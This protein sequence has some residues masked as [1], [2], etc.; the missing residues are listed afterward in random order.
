MKLVISCEHGGNEIPKQYENIFKNNQAV[1]DTHKGFDLGALDLFRYLKPLSE[2]S[3]SSK[4]SRLLIELNRSLH[5]K[6]LFSK[7]T[8]PLS[9]SEKKVIIENQYF[10]YRNEIES[11]ISKLIFNG[12][13]VLHISIHSFTPILNGIERDC[14][15]GILYDSKKQ[16]EKN[17]A[18]QLKSKINS[19][20]PVYNVR[21]NYPYLGKADGFTTYLRTKFKKNYIGIEI[22]I[23]QLFSKENRMDTD[24][25]KTVFSAVKELITPKS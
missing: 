11:Q 7:F 24:V 19:I 6:V 9:H 17:L 4:I 18:K 1:L 8:Q 21:F 12:T 14:D 25:K 15:I 23:N 20:N 5:H 16:I 22:E 3:K 2:Y 13:T 10:S